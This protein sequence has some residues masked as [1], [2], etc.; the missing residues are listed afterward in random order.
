VLK[1]TYTCSKKKKKTHTH[2]LKKK[3]DAY[4]LILFQGLEGG[5]Q[6]EGE[7]RVWETTLEI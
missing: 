1:D 3:K 6:V 5:V 7:M 2:L 4:T